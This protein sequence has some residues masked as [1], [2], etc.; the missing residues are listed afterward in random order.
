MRLPLPVA[1]LL[2]LLLPAALFAEKPFSF[3]ETPG[4]LPKTAVPRH[5][6]LRIQPDLVARTTTGTARIELDVLQPVRELVLNALDLEIESAALADNPARPQP[7]T[8]RVDASKQTLTL[9]LPPN[10]AGELV[11]HRDEQLALKLIAPG[12]YALPAGQ[13]VNIELKHT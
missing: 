10:A 7:L 12:R 8:T 6:E 13:A 4:Q 9:T 11:V 2:A 1:S 5:Y 3:A